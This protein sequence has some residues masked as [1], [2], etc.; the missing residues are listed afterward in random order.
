MTRNIGA[1]A[2][3]LE[4]MSFSHGAVLNASAVA[5]ECAIERRTVVNY[6]DILEDLLLGFRIPVFTRLAR[7]KTISHPKFYYFDTGVFRSL[8][9]RGPLDSDAAIHGAGLEGLVA[10]HLRAWV[11]YSGCRQELTYWHP[12]GDSEVDFI[13]HGDIGC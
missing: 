7:R 2:R 13:V 3:F 8:R 4:E 5:R 9:P 6:I 11:E 12:R 10:Q 1:F